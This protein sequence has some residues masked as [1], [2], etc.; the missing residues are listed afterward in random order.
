M[1]YTF[2]EEYFILTS[3]NF[4]FSNQL[5]CRIARHLSF[6][7]LFF[8]HVL[9][10]RYYLYDL[11]YLFDSRTYIIRLQNMLLFLPVSVFYAYFA[12]YFL[13][14]GFILKGKYVQLFI[15][16]F[17]MSVVLLLCSYLLSNQFNIRLAWD[18]P[19]ERQ[20]IVRQID[21][22]A[23]NGLVYPLTVST[24]AIGIKMA[25]G[26]YLKQKENELLL[27]QKIKKEIQLLKTQIHPRLIFHSLS[28]IYNDTLDGFKKSPAMLLRLSDLLSYLLYE[29]SEEAVLLEKELSMTDDYLG[30]E[31]LCYGEALQLTVHNT[32]NP[33]EKLIAPL[34]LLPILECVF[35]LDIISK[36]QH[37][38]MNL[39]LRMQEDDFY[40]TLMLQSDPPLK[41]ELFHSNERLLQ[42]QK[43]LAALYAGR[44]E[45]KIFAEEKRLVI[46]LTMTLSSR[47]EKQDIITE[48]I[49]TLT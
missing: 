21:F 15:I 11:K 14:P 19:L 22:T 42:V 2:K 27:E 18:L 7:I 44:Y 40:F 48:K 5:R 25:K 36:K 6:W 17:L 3:Q 20:S 12:M 13:L 26:W 1:D 33:Q 47:I 46:A 35:E 9:L 24:F 41:K 16:V 23:G 28:A 45:F 4:I 32:I 29:S 34:L 49:T 8:L 39:Y 30:L 10:F 31:K 37:L 43:R 38:V